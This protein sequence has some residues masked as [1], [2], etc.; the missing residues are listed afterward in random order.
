MLVHVYNHGVWAH[1]A[2]LAVA[3][4]TSRSGLRGILSRMGIQTE[5]LP[6]LKT[7]LG[8]MGRVRFVGRHG[9]ERL[10]KERIADR[11]LVATTCSM[12]SSK[13]NGSVQQ[14]G[15]IAELAE[16]SVSS[17]PETAVT[18]S[19]LAE[20]SLVAE[21]VDISSVDES[22]MT[23]RTTT[24][25]HKGA[26]ESGHGDGVIEL[27]NLPEMDVGDAYGLS[28]EDEF[29]QSMLP[30][31]QDDP[32]LSGVIDE[33]EDGDACPV[34]LERSPPSMTS[35]RNRFMNLAIPEELED[36]LEMDAIDDAVRFSE[37]TQHKM[38]LSFRVWS[39]ICGA[40]EWNPEDK[41]VSDERL[42]QF[43]V[44]CLH[45]DCG[46]CYSLYSFRDVYVPMLFRYFDANGYT[47][48]GGIRERIKH[49]IQA[50]VKN[51]D[52]SADQIP[53]EQGKEPMCEWDI[54]FIASVYPKG[55][56]DRVQVMSWMTVG[57]HTGVRGI[58]LATTYWEDMKV[59]E[60]VPEAPHFK[61]ITLVF[62]ETKGDHN[63][64]H[65][66]TI[67]GSVLNVAT[68]SSDPVY[69]LS[70]LVKE[71][72]GHETELTQAT[73]SLKG[74][75][76]ACDSQSTMSERINSV[77][78]YCGYPSRM[79]SCH[80]LRS[81]FLC[82]ALL[83][84]A[85]DT[86]KEVN[87]PEV[88]N[89]CALVAGWHVR[90]RHQEKYCKSAFLR[91][92][93]SSRLIQAGSLQ[94]GTEEIVARIVGVGSVAK[95]RLTPQHFHGLDTPLTPDWPESTKVQLWVD[96][97]SGLVDNVLEQHREDLSGA[98]LVA[99]KQSILNGIYVHLAGRHLLLE[100]DDL[101]YRNTRLE[102]KR[103]VKKWAEER[104][105]VNDDTRWLHTYLSGTVRGIAVKR[106][107]DYVFDEER[108]TRR[109]KAVAKKR[110]R[111]AKRS[112]GGSSSMARSKSQQKRAKKKSG[113][114]VAWTSEETAVLCQGVIKFGAKWAQISTADVLLNRTGPNCKD[115]MRTLV[116]QTGGGEYLDVAQ[117]WLKGSTFESVQWK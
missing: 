31:V 66:I 65:P 64:N 81:G 108:S 114:R 46:V 22:N 26:G 109:K 62:R 55:C 35:S 94:A 100:D 51:G 71:Q 53:K 92:I 24:P 38:E 41:E 70:Q 105:E 67:E 44:L 9:V 111:S 13:L 20:V 16:S 5:S 74:R 49:K 87:F 29:P 112:G 14:S 33:K 78:V 23:L 57:L 110:R 43:I 82:T 113:R 86:G 90:S 80:S 30:S 96:Q 93:V 56:S 60:P 34:L 83:K 97:L 45:R 11:A 25:L 88:W 85:V 69:W 18:L 42:L 95:N 52:L 77:A 101:S 61:Q 91:C 3:F 37:S 76:F 72:L 103:S 75:V 39:H 2:D 79:F 1:I 8:L 32:S 47:Y 36:D 15:S 104:F 84:H 73:V 89:K 117:C 17:R 28:F 63:W 115:R 10:I 6:E 19:L 48:S 68:G 116:K 27:D 98:T 107:N 40:R 12:I 102:S 99:A 58:S 50:M 4:G 7:R 59:V 54:Q 21:E 106:A